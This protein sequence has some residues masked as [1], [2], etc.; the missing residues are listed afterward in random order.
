MQWTCS[1]G[2]MEPAM[3]ILRRTDRQNA[4]PAIKSARLW[5]PRAPDAIDGPESGHAHRA[6]M[7]FRP[8]RR[9]RAPQHPSAIAPIRHGPD[10]RAHF[11]ALLD[12]KS[13]VSGKSVSVSVDLGGRVYLKK[14]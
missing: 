2:L 8:P 11:R 13:V 7:C 10:H 6:A 9:S 4:L 5:R 3:M 12:R 14:K 1:C